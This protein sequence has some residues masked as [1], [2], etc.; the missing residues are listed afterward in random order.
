MRAASP[1]SL[2]RFLQPAHFNDSAA[3]SAVVRT[4]CGFFRAT[5]LVAAVGT[6]GPGF[7]VSTMVGGREGFGGKGR[8]WG[9]CAKDGWARG[10]QAE[11]VTCVHADAN[12]A[13]I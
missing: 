2:P 10:G 12:L 3:V 11:G 7:G 8:E 1:F 9:G 13:Q 5:A 4:F 6:V